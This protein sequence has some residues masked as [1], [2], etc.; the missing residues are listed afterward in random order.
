M[1]DITTASLIA[2]GIGLARY[3]PSASASSLAFNTLTT[4]QLLHALSCRS[5]AH[6]LLGKERMPRNT[7]LELALGGSLAAQ[8]LA[9]LIPAVRSGLGLA[10]LGA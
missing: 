7:K 6:T 4:A 1:F 8:V 2:Y 5:Q 9:T 10:P 3:G